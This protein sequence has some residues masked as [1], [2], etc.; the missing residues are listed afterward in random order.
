MFWNNRIVRMTVGLVLLVAAVLVLLPA[1]TGY[2]SLDGTVN[3]RFAVITAPIDGVVLE[4]P[5]K[6]GTPV[7]RGQSLLAIR[8]ARVNRAVLTSLE[9]ERNTAEERVTALRR[10]RVTLEGLAEELESRVLAY[11]AALTADLRNELAMLRENVQ[12]SQAQEVA[13]AS[14]LTRRVTLG[15]SGIV[16]E[17]SIEQARAA[18]ITS[19]GQV[20]TTRLAAQR[21]EDRLTALE[22]GIFVGDGQ[23]DVPYSRQRRDELLIQIADIDQR[24]AENAIRAEE[25]SLQL[26]EERRRVQ[27]LT[28]SALTSSFAGVAWR[29]N[30]VGGSNVVVGN[31][32]LRLL[33]CRDLF[34]DILV[35]EVDYDQIFPGRMAEVRLLGREETIA[36]R[37]LSVRGSAA[38]IEEVTLAATPPESQGR[39]ARIRVALDT[40]DMNVDFLNYC[41]VGRSV[42]VRFERRSIP[43][44]RWWSS[45]WFSI[46]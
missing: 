39:N 10:Q 30:V 25:I 22:S 19:G 15:T 42:Q 12:V 46:S 8:N 7:E 23:N 36:G 40:T 1:I 17:S 5:P 24:I 26:S 29:N 4:S 27:T 37:V 43:W 20:E 41:Q 45:V 2:T 9:A 6:V 21:I 16:A 44:R 31:E 35:L 11:Q 3:A 13:A 34:V 14:E 33:D 38:V 28:S 32:L 18:Q